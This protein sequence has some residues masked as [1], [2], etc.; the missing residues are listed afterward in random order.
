MLK[1]ETYKLEI[2]DISPS[3]DLYTYTNTKTNRDDLNRLAL[4]E[5]ELKLSPV[6]YFYTNSK[7]FFF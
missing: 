5:V 2:A 7:C 4:C 1:Q 3:N 6:S